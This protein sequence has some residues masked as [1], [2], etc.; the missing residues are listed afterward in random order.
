M[1][2]RRSGTGRC[3]AACTCLSLGG[4]PGTGAPGAGGNPPGALRRGGGATVADRSEVGRSGVV[5]AVV[6]ATGVVGVAR[7]VWNFVLGC[8]LAGRRR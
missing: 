1:G 8:W 7:L 2:L 5:P 3:R 4:C 6:A